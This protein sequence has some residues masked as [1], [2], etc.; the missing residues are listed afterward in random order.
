M[1][2]WLACG[3]AIGIASAVARP[4][5]A[6][7]LSG[8]CTVGSSVTNR[9]GKTGTVTASSGSYCTVKYPDGTSGYH[10]SFMLRL[11]GTPQVDP[12]DV[13][14]I[15]P[16][17]YACYAGSPL[18]YQ[19]IDLNVKTGS[20][21]TDVKGKLGAFAYDPKTQL[22]TFKSGSFAGQYA[23]YLG[24]G[25]IGLSAKETTYFATVCSLKK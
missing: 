25:R 8:N 7:E 4:A 13:A 15:K 11:A 22:L 1:R 10:P 12:K 3:L 14:S 16:G 17:T 19:F 9:N 6:Q 23:K 18:Q 24:N 2:A 21:Y 5:L 20:A